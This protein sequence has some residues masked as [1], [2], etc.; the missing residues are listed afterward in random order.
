MPHVVCLH[1]SLI[2]LL[3]LFAV[4]EKKISLTTWFNLHITVSLA[5]PK[6]QPA[7]LAVSCNFKRHTAI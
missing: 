5:L 3:A 4:V 1:R 2:Y 7:V 6:K